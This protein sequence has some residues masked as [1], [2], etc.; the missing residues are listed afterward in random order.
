MRMDP[1]DFDLFAD[2]MIR[3]YILTFL[4]RLYGWG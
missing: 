1:Y 2:V 3:N 4:F